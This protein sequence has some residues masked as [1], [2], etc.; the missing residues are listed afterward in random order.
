MGSGAVKMERDVV[1]FTFWDQ[2]LEVYLRISE[3]P[4]W[5]EP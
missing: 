3:E 1:R 5:D 2:P 4:G